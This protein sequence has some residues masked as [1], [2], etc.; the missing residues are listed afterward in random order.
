MLK[1]FT[2]EGR[3]EC[4]LDAIVSGKIW[5]FVNVTGEHYAARL[6]VAIANEAGYIPIPEFWCNSDDYNALGAHAD[7]LN[8]DEGIDP[9]QAARIVCSTMK[10]VGVAA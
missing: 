6:G 4:G 3:F 10:P 1:E 5:C 9:L 8:A 2:A 7:K